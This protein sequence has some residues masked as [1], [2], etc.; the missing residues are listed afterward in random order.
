MATEA[1]KVNTGALA[2]LV[3][4]SV[5]AM[6][7]ISLALVA[8]VR[9]ELSIEAARKDVQ[10]DAP[11]RALRTQQLDKLQAG[12]PIETAMLQVVGDL[13]ENPRPATPAPK[14]SVA[15]AGPG[16]SPAPT[17]ALA[18]G[19]SV[20]EV[21]GIAPPVGTAPGPTPQKDGK[22]PTPTTPTPSAGVVSGAPPATPAAP[23]RGAAPGPAA[24]QHGQ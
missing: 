22:L 20:G 10:A 1:D 24:S 18:S 7:G 12:V 3:A 2:T 9:D 15:A 16:T 13:K 23:S 4:V 14:P 21:P 19:G 17:G 6:V 8:F 11:Y 5:F